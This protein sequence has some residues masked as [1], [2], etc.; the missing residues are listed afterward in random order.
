[1]PRAFDIADILT[2]GCDASRPTVCAKSMMIIMT[3]PPPEPGRTR[4]S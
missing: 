3:T 4:A 1:M 2:A